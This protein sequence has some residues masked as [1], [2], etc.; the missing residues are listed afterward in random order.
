MDEDNYVKKL[1]EA[2]ISRVS[3]E[4]EE[5]KSGYERYKINAVAELQKYEKNIARHESEI[6]QM[7]EHLEKL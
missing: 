5:I 3:V 4:L 6:K 2:R 1:L 7:Q